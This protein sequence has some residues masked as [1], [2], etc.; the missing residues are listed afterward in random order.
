MSEFRR[1]KSI[2][3][4]LTF[5]FFGFS[6]QKFKLKS[7]AIKNPNWKSVN[8]LGFA[9]KNSNYL[10]NVIWIFGWKMAFCP[11]VFR[12]PIP[13]REVKV[14]HPWKLKKRGLRSLLYWM[15]P[16]QVDDSITYLH[17]VW[18]SQ[19]KSHSTLRA[20][21]ATFSLWVDKNESFWKPEAFNQIS[22][23]RQVTLLGQKF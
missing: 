17:S 3:K 18:K 20:K 21:R 8:F 9:I 4:L 1:Q 14:I 10:M 13:K 19:K 22:V 15:K 16:Y 11:S 2:L 12:D 7:F 6:R 5:T 23:T